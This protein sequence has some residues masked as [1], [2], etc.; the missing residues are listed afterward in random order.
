MFAYLSKQ[1]APEIAQPAPVVSQAVQAQYQPKR[2]SIFDYVAKRASWELVK[3]A[4]G[5][6][7][8][9]LV[10]IATYDAW[11]KLKLMVGGGWRGVKDGVA[12]TFEPRFDD[13]NYDVTGG[14]RFG[15]APKD[16]RFTEKSVEMIDPNIGGISFAPDYQT[17][18]PMGGHNPGHMDRLVDRYADIYEVDA[19][20]LRG[21]IT[22][23]SSWNPEAYNPEGGGIGAHGLGQLRRQALEYCGITAEEAKRD[24]AA[25]IRCTAAWVSEKKKE[26]GGDEA[27]AV[28]SYHCGPKCVNKRKGI[29]YLKQIVKNY[30]TPPPAP[31]GVSA[32]RVG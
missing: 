14:G 10:L 30:D 8:T 25:A 32:K 27:E 7:V 1:N 21:I 24:P 13:A 3:L 16:K 28:Q 9:F 2:E 20:S 31:K 23:E 6:Y 19:G 17:A 4:V 5:A 29:G 18:A 15:S 26:Q 11:M 22:Q 12:A